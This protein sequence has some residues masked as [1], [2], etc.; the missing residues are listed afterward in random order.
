MLSPTV[1]PDARLAE[2]GIELPELPRPT[3]TYVPFRRDGG[4]VYLAGQTCEWN[5][6]MLYTGKV[7]RDVDLE[8]GQAAARICALN[9][10]AALRS[11]LGGSL[12]PV[13]ACLRLGGFVNA[14][15]DFPDVPL[16]VNGASDLIAD[17]FGREVAQHARTA[18]GVATLPQCAAVEVDAIFAVREDRTGA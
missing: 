8:T 18:V 14:A 11:A 10:L 2:L 16:V 9:L 13:N 5:G 15:P 4:I 6:R 12:G 7:G 17:I 1:P 3:G